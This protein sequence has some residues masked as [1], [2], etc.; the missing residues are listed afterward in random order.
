MSIYVEA[1]D[2]SRTQ[3]DQ[4]ARQMTAELNDAGISAEATRR[5]V[6]AATE[7]LAAAS[8][9]DADLIVMGTRGRTG[10]AR[11]VLGSV[12]R[13][14]L[15]HASCSVLVVREGSSETASRPGIPTRGSPRSRPY[16]QLPSV[17]LTET[18]QRRTPGAPAGQG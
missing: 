12:A 5:E 6:D 16:E 7:I 4:L 2:A 15:Q 17:G 9:S 10:L 11:F 1:A 14:V 13:N 18:L 8:A 3:H